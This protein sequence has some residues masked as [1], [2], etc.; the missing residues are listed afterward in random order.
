MDL[1]TLENIGTLNSLNGFTPKDSSNPSLNPPILSFTTNTTNGYAFSSLSTTCSTLAAMTPSKKNS[2]NLSAIA[3]TSS[4][5]DLLNGSCKCVSINTK[6]KPTLDQHRYVLNTLQRYDPNSEFPE[7]ETPFPPDYTFSKDNR[8]VTDHDKQVVEQHE[9]RLPFRSA[10]CTLLYLAYNTRAD[11]LFAVCKLAKACVCPGELDF[12]ALIWLIGY[13]RRRPYYAI[14]FYPDATTNPVYDICRQ[15][16]IPHSDLTVFSDASWQDCP[17][18][19]RSTVGYM[20]FHNGA[21]IE[22]NSTMP[23]P[24]AMSTS[25]AEY[26]AAC[27]ASMAT[28]HIRMLLYDMTYLGT[29]HWRESMQRLP[30]IPSIL[31]IDNEATVQIAKNGKLTRKTRHIERRFHYVRQGQQDGIHQLHWI[32]C[33]S[34]LADILTKTQVSSKIDQHIDKVF[35]TLPDHMLQSTSESTEI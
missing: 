25:E 34:Q 18:T 31:M 17:D 1:F 3:L 29:K 26:M 4:S 30:T 23:T 32:P 13:L 5:L 2:K 10:V 21:L 20:I 22:A 11:I 8:P 33:D 14:K 15:H 7:R 27:S 6:T 35:C 16:R 9:K 12:R 24:I 28:A 19:G